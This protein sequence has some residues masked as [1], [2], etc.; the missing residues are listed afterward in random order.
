MFP[1]SVFYP[2]GTLVEPGTTVRPGAPAPPP[3]TIFIVETATPYPTVPFDEPTE[4]P[5]PP[6][7]PLSEHVDPN[8][9]WNGWM[10]KSDA[11][12]MWIVYF[13]VGLLASMFMCII[14]VLCCCDENRPMVRVPYVLPVIPERTVFHRHHDVMLALFYPRG[15]PPEDEEE[16]AL[17]IDAGSHEMTELDFETYGT[18]SERFEDMDVGLSITRGVNHHGRPEG[19]LPTPRA[20]NMTNKRVGATSRHAV[21]SCY[22][23]ASSTKKDDEIPG[24]RD[25][26]GDDD[27][28]DIQAIPNYV[29]Q[30]IRSAPRPPA[31]GERF[32]FK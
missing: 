25:Y 16:V 3:V 32:F 21:M 15:V 13:A 18:G 22:H 17:E 27:D 10:L 5:L 12:L 28:S 14:V 26:S 24:T 11:E 19:R 4:A 23:S 8:N 20:N 29:T 30:H 31:V 1:N 7:P 9:W 6:R 2:P